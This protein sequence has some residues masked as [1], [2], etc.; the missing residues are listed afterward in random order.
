M[1][2]QVQPVSRLRTYSQRA[3]T[4]RAHSSTS[5]I[6][7]QTAGC[8]GHRWTLRAFIKHRQHQWP[9]PAPF[10]G[11]VGHRTTNRNRYTYIY[12]STKWIYP[13]SGLTQ[14]PQLMAPGHMS[15]EAATMLQLLA[16]QI[17]RQ[18]DRQPHTHRG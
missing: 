6:H 16:P 1:C 12:I 10:S 17:P 13:A 7:I 8:A 2:P 5:Y 14:S 4:H 15:S 9:C 18:T 11:W 3:P